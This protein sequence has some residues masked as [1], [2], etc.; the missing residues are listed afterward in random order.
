VKRFLLPFLLLGA[1]A[2]DVA[3]SP[4]PAPAVAVKFDPAAKV[5]PVPNDLAR[6]QQ[7]G[8]NEVPSSPTTSAA[9]AEFN[10]TYLN[11]MAGFPY[12]T[13]AQVLFT[14]ALDPATVN[15]SSVIVLDVTNP[16]A[17]GPVT[18]LM[19]VF[20]PAADAID[21]PP[22]AG[23]WT[24]AHRYAVAIIAGNV[25]LKGAHGEKVIG[26]P[27]WPLVSSPSPLVRCPGGAAGQP[28][29]TS[30]DCAL[31]VDIIP[32]AETDSEKRLTD[33][34]T[35][36]I[37]LERVREGYA[38]ILAGIATLAHIDTRDVAMVWTFSIVDAGEVTFDPASG[39]IPFPNDVLRS[40]TTGKVTLP[41]PKTGAPLGASDCAAATDPTIL[42]YCGVN[43]LDGFSTIAYPISAQS[44][45]A[46]AV[47][48]ATID[49]A[50]LSNQD[51]GL[52]SLASLLPP[53][54]QAPIAYTPCLNC[55]TTEAPPQQLQWRLDAPLD[56]KTTYLAYVTGD[57]TDDTG[58]KVVAN[59]VFALLRLTNPIAVGG[60][61]QVSI[62]TDGQAS[63]LEPLR[64]AL[65]LALDALALAGQVSRDDVVLAWTFTTQSE[66]T[67]LDPLYAYP[68][69][70]SLPSLPSGVVI[71]EDATSLYVGTATAAGI[72]VDAIGKVYIGVFGTPVAVTGPGGT[73]DLGNPSPQ[74]ISFTLFVPNPGQVPQPA[75]GYPLTI[76]GHGLTRD[77]NDSL[78]I[79]NA[80]AK[81]GQATIAT[82]VIF[83]GERS[84]CTGFGK[85][86]G[87]VDEAACADPTMMVCDEDPLIGRCVARDA[88]TR[89]ACPGLGV[90]GPDPTGN[91]I[92]QAR[93]L[94][95]C[96]ADG[97]CEGGD[98][99]RDSGGRPIISGWN[100]FSLTNFFA[101]R[102]NLRQ[103]VIDLAQLVQ[104]LRVSGGLSLAA[105]IAAAGGTATF[106][107][108]KLGYVGQS[109]GGILGA[110]FNA[111]SPDTNEVVL[112]V[113]GGDLVQII[114]TS[115]SFAP[116]KAQLLAN[117]AALQINPGTP[118]FDQFI[119]TAQWILDPA[120]PANMGWR[121]THPSLANPSR[122]V[123]LQ[124]IQDDQTVP[125]VSNRALLRAAD[126]PFSDMPPAFG[127][128]PPLYCYEFTDAIEGFDQTTVPLAGRHGFMLNPPAPTVQSGMLTAK[129]QLQAATFLATGK[130]P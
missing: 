26:S 33:Q 62:L 14:G 10:R 68:K 46:G 115:P 84:S 29:L 112:D 41:N 87:T 11:Q 25:G 48:Q 13:T 123:F 22:P 65:S 85:S 75:G 34:T 102:D 20:D 60:K 54:N 38:P 96:A 126:R 47:A 63:Q 124:F 116:V 94:G 7:T 55:A 18:G 71:F 24:R 19:P 107:L 114:L 30:P 4:P 8:K 80:L 27:A 58:K 42:L 104:T 69:S 56:E 119:A 93:H 78:L 83:H 44:P 101:T 2:P 110:L 122:G 28:D 118:A 70:L 97:K 23:G 17:P 113:A 57:V 67:L 61:S 39:V 37:G 16:G 43:T 12:E 117:L 86:A 89:I 109:L 127:C 128:A 5:V 98:F 49:G 95:A 50:S 72:P 77:R 129:A 108:S 121:L 79:A 40:P 111:A 66:G 53:G 105:R 3:Q 76:F 45:S 36:A 73:F 64:S 6:N 106:D 35:S 1:C 32:S 100:F 103:Q 52:I 74:P 15:A 31:A 21:V 125:N 130:L 99:A 82:D 120:D 51:V 9:Q 81:A 59:P 90:A 92:C 91:L 88:S